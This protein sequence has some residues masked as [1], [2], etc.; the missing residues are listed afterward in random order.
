MIQGVNL[1]DYTMHEAAGD[2]IVFAPV[3][4]STSVGPVLGPATLACAKE[5][6]PNLGGII[7][8]AF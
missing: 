6:V 4:K 2:V 5:L 7:F 8:S 3:R 1:P